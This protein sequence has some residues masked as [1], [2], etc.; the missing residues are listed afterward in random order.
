[1]QAV[2]G[3]LLNPITPLVLIIILGVQLMS[4]APCDWDQSTSSAAPLTQAIIHSVTSMADHDP[5]TPRQ[6]LQNS[7]SGDTI[8]F[9]P[10]VF[11]PATP[12]TILLTSGLPAI[13][14]VT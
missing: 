7:G 12:A 5:G 3:L 13:A 2:L 4:P 14:G 1:M 11:P 9:A 6:A 10:A 8:T